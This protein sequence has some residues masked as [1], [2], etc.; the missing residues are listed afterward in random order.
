MDGWVGVFKVAGE[1]DPFHVN[2]GI[3]DEK[4]VQEKKILNHLTCE[5]R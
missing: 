3:S 1:G 5:R 4:Y 2:Q